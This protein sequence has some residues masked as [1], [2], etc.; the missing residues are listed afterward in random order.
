MPKGGG[1]GGSGSRLPRLPPKAWTEAEV[2]EKVTED[3]GVQGCLESWRESVASSD[4]AVE[5]GSEDA[6]FSAERDVVLR[7]GAYLNNP[8][9]QGG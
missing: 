9:H 1:K 6:A 8:D 5:G 2:R 7:L 4:T 3:A